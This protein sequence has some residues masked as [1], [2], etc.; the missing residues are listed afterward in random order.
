[1]RFILCV[2]LSNALAGFA[3]AQN[4]ELASE[5][6]AL[7]PQY[8]SIPYCHGSQGGAGRAPALRGRTWEVGAVRDIVV[9]GIPDTSMPSFGERLTDN[10]TDAIVAYVMS[11]SIA[12][13]G[14]ASAAAPP[15]EAS[16]IPVNIED[17]PASL[18]GDPERG[19]ALFFESSGERGCTGCHRMGR[20]DG[21]G[22]DLSTAKEREPRELLRDILFPDVESTNAS[23][24]TFLAIELED[25]ERVMG[26]VQEESETALRV[27]DLST[28]PPVLRRIAKESVTRMEPVP[29][30]PMPK[31]FGELYTWKELLDVLAFLKGRAVSYLEVQ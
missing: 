12:P 16:Q 31:N 14:D 4:S 1:M 18:V 9:D 11:I 19:A 13:E 5:G 3:A 24:R 2:V 15:R 25:G 30:S 21:V 26:I 7:F 22:P 17:L 20:G 8:C 10:E 6:R 27:H 28:R 23:A 29:G